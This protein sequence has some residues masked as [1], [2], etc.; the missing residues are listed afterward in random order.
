MLVHILWLEGRNP[1]NPFKVIHLLF[2]NVFVALSGAV[3]AML[4]KQRPSLIQKWII[5]YWEIILACLAF[6][7]AVQFVFGMD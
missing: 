3:K 5:F 1:F 7:V 6:G 2:I 4:F